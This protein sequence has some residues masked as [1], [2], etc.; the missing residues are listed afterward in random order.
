MGHSHHVVVGHAALLGPPHHLPLQEVG[1]MRLRFSSLERP[2]RTSPC[3]R[4][5]TIMVASLSPYV[6]GVEMC[7]CRGAHL[8]RRAGTLL[9][10]TSL[11]G[12]V[13]RP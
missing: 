10:A 11:W 12:A 7:A 9:R 6:L 13:A 4:G 5:E 2:P 3:A 8:V 1:G